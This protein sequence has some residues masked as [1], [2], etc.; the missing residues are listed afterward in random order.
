[1]HSFASGTSP[2][3]AASRSAASTNHR[4]RNSSTCRQ[5]RNCFSESVS[6]SSL[7]C[8]NVQP[9]HA[10]TFVAQEQITKGVPREE[11]HFCRAKPAPVGEKTVDV[12]MAH[13]EIAL[14]L[15]QPILADENIHRYE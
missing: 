14:N 10:S 9:V 13:G 7:P 8:A 12:E 5:A 6:F 11:M 1:M 15:F 4:S 2:W 3:S